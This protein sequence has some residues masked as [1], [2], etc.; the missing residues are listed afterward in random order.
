M[1]SNRP[2]LLIMTKLSCRPVLPE[3]M[4]LNSKQ[5]GAANIR[6]LGW[7]AI[8]FAV[9]FG[10]VFCQFTQR[11]E[12]FFLSDRTGEGPDAKD[13][14]YPLRCEYILSFANVVILVDLFIIL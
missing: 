11:N 12:E 8:W 2:N 14:F 6:L 7:A 4:F 10:G 1:D 9:D 5:L 3:S 13:F